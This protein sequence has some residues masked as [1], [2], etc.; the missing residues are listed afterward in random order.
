MENT[1]YLSLGT[2]LG[3]KV[4]N[5]K[6]AVSALSNQLGR[7]INI[8]SLYQSAPWGFDTDDDFFNI[9]VSIESKYSPIDSLKICQRIERELGRAEKTKKGY[10]SRLIDIDIVLFNDIAIKSEDLTIP[11]MHMKQRL[12][13][14][15]PLLEIC[16][17]VVIAEN[18]TNHLI[19]RKKVETIKKL[20]D[21]KH[22]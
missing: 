1:I 5:L 10:E 19:S 4:E 11:H 14:L 18:Y 20:K 8:S 7:V 15:E 6:N 12:F 13:V 21:F 9:V 22:L 17:N 16:N 3:S 2:N